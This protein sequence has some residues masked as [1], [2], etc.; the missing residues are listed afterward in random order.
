MS[1]IGGIAF[2]VYLM[3]MIQFRGNFDTKLQEKI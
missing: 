1:M 2:I 3:Q